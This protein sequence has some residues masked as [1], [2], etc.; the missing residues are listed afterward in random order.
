MN[1]SIYC[2]IIIVR[3]ILLDNKK[4]NRFKNE[5]KE[6]KVAVLGIGISNIPAIKYL[7]SLGTKWNI[8]N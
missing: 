6:K 8:T 2:N 5:I 1:F 7:V 4:L 3:V